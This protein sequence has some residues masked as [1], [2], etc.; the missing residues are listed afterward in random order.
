VVGDAEPFGEADG[1]VDGDAD[2]EP[3]GDADGDGGIEGV[4]SD[5]PGWIDGAVVGGTVGTWPR[6]P[7]V[8]HAAETMR[9]PAS[10]GTRKG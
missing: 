7:E 1:D 2:P 6:P 9:R 4:S 10:A 3:D 5:G 8:V